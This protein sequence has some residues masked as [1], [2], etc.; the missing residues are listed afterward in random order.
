MLITVAPTVRLVPL[1]TEAPTLIPKNDPVVVTMG[2]PFVVAQP[3]V[4]RV[5]GITVVL[6]AVT[7]HCTFTVSK[8]Q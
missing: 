2:L 1:T 4:E 7:M 3:V 6:E 5:L 8:G